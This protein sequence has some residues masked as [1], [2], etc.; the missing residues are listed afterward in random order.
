MEKERHQQG[1]LLLHQWGSELTRSKEKPHYQHN[2]ATKRLRIAQCGGNSDKKE[3]SKALE[4][5]PSY[6]RNIVEDR[7]IHS[8]MQC[9]YSGFRVLVRVRFW[10]RPRQQPQEIVRSF[11]V[12]ISVAHEHHL[13]P[14][15]FYFPIWSIAKFGYFFFSR[16][17]TLAKL[18]TWKK[19]TELL[20]LLLLEAGMVVASCSHTS[21][22]V[23]TQI[24][25]KL[26]VSHV[27]RI[28]VV[29]SQKLTQICCCRTVGFL[30]YSSGF[31]VKPCFWRWTN[32]QGFKIW[33]YLC[34]SFCH[35]LP[36]YLSIQNWNLFPSQ[37]SS[38]VVPKHKTHHTTMLNN[39]VQKLHKKVT[40]F[41]LHNAQARS[42][43]YIFNQTTA[44]VSCKEDGVIIF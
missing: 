44:S 12:E 19:S 26:V 39:V 35:H 17:T 37:C 30:V 29:C 4:K 38:N 13:N 41:A 28:K 33:P 40:D 22:N 1:A 10:T 20:Q 36:S 31:R 43:Q 18:Q 6:S 8:G 42:G 34:K 5:N 27:C 23:H 15:H 21:S 7:R 32:F 3:S 25:F 2:L 24:T 16:I 14:Y 11:E 9:L